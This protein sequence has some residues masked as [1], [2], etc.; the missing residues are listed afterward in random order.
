MQHRAT[1]DRSPVEVSCTR[2][3]AYPDSGL[4]EKVARAIRKW[5]WEDDDTEARRVVAYACTHCGH[6]HI[7]R[8]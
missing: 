3:K 6:W 5:G 8:S 2:K 7:G 1:D 4:A